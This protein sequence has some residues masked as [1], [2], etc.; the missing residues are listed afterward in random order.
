MLRSTLLAAALAP[1]FVLGAG[2]ANAQT[3]IAWWHAMGGRLG[4]VV[5]EIA[6]RFNASQSDYKITPIFKGNYEET[7]TA[8]IAAFRAGSLQL[9]QVVFTHG[10]NNQLPQSRQELY[11][12]PATPEGV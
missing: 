4:E 3:E 10:D 5:N 6:T 12:F 9:F 8:T 2:A 11:T 1:A 7:L